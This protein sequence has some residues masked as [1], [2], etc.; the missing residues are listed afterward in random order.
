MEIGKMIKKFSVKILKGQA[1]L[2]IIDKNSLTD[3]KPFHWELKR[4]NSVQYL[5]GSGQIHF[6]SG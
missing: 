6:R 5:G 4:E 2:G 3:E 1:S